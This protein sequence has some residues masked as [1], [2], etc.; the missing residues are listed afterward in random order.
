MPPA[1]NAHLHRPSVHDTACRRII[2]LAHSSPTHTV[3]LF[4]LLST[5]AYYRPREHSLYSCLLLHSCLWP[6]YHSP[7]TCPSAVTDQLHYSSSELALLSLP[8]LRVLYSVSSTKDSFFPPPRYGRIRYKEKR[9]QEPNWTE[10]PF[11][12]DPE[13]RTRLPASQIHSASFPRTS[14]KPRRTTCAC[15][16]APRNLRS[17]RQNRVGAFHMASK[18]I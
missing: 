4:Y 14:S 2:A 10:V 12:R 8:R 15:L 5:F 16:V 3:Y 17:H 11:P 1:P 18:A 6:S 9:H 13:R 7:P